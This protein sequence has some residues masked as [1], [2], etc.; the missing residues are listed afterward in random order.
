LVGGKEEYNGTVQPLVAGNRLFG[1]AV[2]ELPMKQRSLVD[3][4]LHW[5]RRIPRF[6]HSISTPSWEY[7][8]TIEFRIC[9]IHAKH[10]MPGQDAGWD[11]LSRSAWRLI[12]STARTM[13]LRLITSL[14]ICE[15]RSHYL[16][17]CPTTGL[18]VDAADF[19]TSYGRY[20]NDPVGNAI[21]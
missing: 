18:A 11:C 20:A 5:T 21:L 19:N 3:Y 15:Y 6:E 9:T 8:A 2:M 10:F 7:G 1:Q 4:T 17:I 14:Q 16:V 13:G 12:L